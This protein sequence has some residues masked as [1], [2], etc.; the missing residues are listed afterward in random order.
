MRPQ[1]NTFTSLRFGKLIPSAAPGSL[2]LQKVFKALSR[3]RLGSSL[4]ELR[5]FEGAAWAW[6]ALGDVSVVQHP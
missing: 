6:A 3:R 4:L 1:G 5:C 2:N